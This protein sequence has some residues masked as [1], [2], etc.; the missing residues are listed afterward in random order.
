MF[1]GVDC[2]TQTSAAV[3]DKEMTCEPPDGNIITVGA[4]RCRYEK[5]LFLRNS[6]GKGASGIHV[7]S[8][9]TKCDVDI[10]NNSCVNVVS[11]S[12]TA[13]FLHESGLAILRSVFVLMEEKL[14]FTLV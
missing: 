11:S 2:A 1:F 7:I 9:Q 13:V 10:R 8:F 4:K 5:A 12:G 3:I 6:T 14:T